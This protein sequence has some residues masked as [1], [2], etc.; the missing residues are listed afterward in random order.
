MIK[1]RNGVVRSVPARG[2]SG[3]RAQGPLGCPRSTTSDIRGHHR[4]T[5][6]ATR[7][8]RGGNARGNDSNLLV[9][10]NFN[11]MENFNM[12]QYLSG[13]T[14]VRYVPVH[15]ILVCF[16]PIHFISI[17]FI[18]IRYVPVCYI[19]AFLRHCMFHP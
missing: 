16:I 1:I 9:V 13:S 12:D 4:S 18:P 14:Q 8:P 11:F 3:H 19:L 5:T 7:G 10:Q 17:S 6:S 2:G 15:F